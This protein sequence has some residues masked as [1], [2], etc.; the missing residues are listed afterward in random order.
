[1]D[2]RRDLAAGADEHGGGGGRG[3][4][5]VL[6]AAGE[7]PLRDRGRLGALVGRFDD[8]AGAFA[9]AGAGLQLG[10]P[11]AAAGAAQRA[12][13]PVRDGE[14]GLVVAPGGGQGA[15]QDGLLLGREGVGEAGEGGGRGAAPAVDRLLRVADGAGGVAGAEEVGEHAQLG[16][17]GVLELVQQHH[18]VH[19]AG[20]RR[21]GGDLCGD[22]G[23]EGDL[24]GEVQCRFGGADLGEALQQRHQG[25]AL[26][27]HGEDLRDVLRGGASPALDLQRDPGEVVADLAQVL[28]ELLGGDEV[29]GEGGGEREQRG[30]EGC[31]GGVE[32]QGVVPALDDLVGELP[33]RGGGHHRQLGVDADGERVLAHEVEGEAVVGV[34]HGALAHEVIPA[35]LE[36]ARQRQ[37][38]GAQRGGEG[39]EPGPDPFGELV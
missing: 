2:E 3:V 17:G 25:E 20:E 28:G 9:G 23:G 13:E 32:V 37:A 16:D 22:A 35:A 15:L 5:R 21:R 7:D 39:G 24:V 29:V 34:D 10:D 26:L 30:G 19:A 27:E 18:A 38:L 36:T 6:G 4:V 11:D 33:G 12:G 1:V 14:D 8:L 31:R